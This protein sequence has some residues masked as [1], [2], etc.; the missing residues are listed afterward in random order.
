MTMTKTKRMKRIVADKIGDAQFHVMCN[1][2]GVDHAIKVIKR[3]NMTVTDEQIARERE[4]ELASQEKWN[5][6]F[7]KEN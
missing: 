3:M 2:W 6:V 4:N 1:M 5:N 7:R